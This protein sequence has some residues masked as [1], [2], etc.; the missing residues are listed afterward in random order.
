MSDSQVDLYPINTNLTITL[1]TGKP[2]H[3]PF[4]EYGTVAAIW[5]G[6]A[7]LIY[8][9]WRLNRRLAVKQEKTA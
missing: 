3:Q 7:W 6:F 5:L 8:K 2:S 4:V 1:P 9:I